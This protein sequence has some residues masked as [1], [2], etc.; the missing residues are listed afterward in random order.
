M[1]TKFPRFS[2][3]DKVNIWL[4]VTAVVVLFLYIIFATRITTVVQFERPTAF[5]TFTSNVIFDANNPLH[6]CLVSD[7]CS[8]YL[9]QTNRGLQALT[10]TEVGGAR[11]VHAIAPKL[12]NQTTAPA[13]V[14]LGANLRKCGTD[15]VCINVKELTPSSIELLTRMNLTGSLELK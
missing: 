10:F 6:S 4:A 7:I 1:T 9:Y 13:I 15:S 5:A 11:D 8:V 3:S 12:V 14:G 2:T